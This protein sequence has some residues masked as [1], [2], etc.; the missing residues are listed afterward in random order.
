[1]RDEKPE[2]ML[3]AFAALRAAWWTFVAHL[4]TGDRYWV[5]RGRA[6]MRAAEAHIERHRLREMHR[7]D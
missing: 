4:Y 3:E 6:Y 1:M 5:W 7:A 2:T